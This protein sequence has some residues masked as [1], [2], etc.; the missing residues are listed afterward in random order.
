[1][2]LKEREDKIN[3]HLPIWIALSAFYLDTELDNTELDR[4]TSVFFQSKLTLNQ[5]KEIDLFEVFPTLQSNLSS[6]AGNWA[7][8]DQK[9]LISA[10]TKTLDKRDNFLFENRVRLRNIFS[11]PMRRDYWK[12][13]EQKYYA[14]Q[15]SSRP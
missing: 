4:I 12:T 1:M 6:V 5:I 14:L 3:Q 11:F 7:G 15:S 13:V 9:Q 8:F 10:C 2:N